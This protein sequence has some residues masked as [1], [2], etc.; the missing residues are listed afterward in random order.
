MKERLI[1]AYNL[2]MYIK[3]S[4]IESTWTFFFLT[5]NF[6]VRSEVGKAS[7]QTL[8]KKVD[9]LNTGREN[10]K[11]LFFKMHSKGQIVYKKSHHFLLTVFIMKQEN[12]HINRKEN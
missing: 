12:K 7:V 11:R 8:E 1:S 6:T 9:K 5:A 3:N 2:Q 4:F 10:G